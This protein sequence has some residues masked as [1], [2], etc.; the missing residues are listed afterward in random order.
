MKWLQG[1]Y[2]QRHNGRHKVFGH[3]FQG[4]Y[5]AVVIDGQAP[6]YFEVVGT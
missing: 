3:L 6:A 5:K 2:T 1:A 4:R